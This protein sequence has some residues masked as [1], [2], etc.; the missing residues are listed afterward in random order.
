MPQPLVLL[1]LGGSAASSEFTLAQIAFTHPVILAAT[2][3]P[4]WARPHLARHLCVD[5]ADEAATTAAVK[6]LAA[7][8]DLGGI[9]TYTGEHLVTAARIAQQLQLP[10]PPTKAL[11]SCADR[12]ELRAKL[13]RHKVPVPVW[14]QAESP[15]AAVTVADGIGY[16]VVIRSRSGS[17]SSGQADRG[18][19]VAGMCARVRS[20]AAP[21]HPLPRGDVLVERRLDGPQVAAE[22]VVLESG[23]VQI[24]AITRTTLGP[25]PARQAV[26]HCVYAHDA[27]LHNRLLRQTVARAVEALG[28]TLGV[29]HIEMTLTSRGPRITD[30]SAHLADDLIPLLVK[31][32]TGVN[33]PRI[34]ADLAVGR[35]PNLAPTRQ[36]AAAVHFA[37]PEVSGRLQHVSV[38]TPG[39]GPLVDRTAVTRE[40]GHQVE[41][42][43]QATAQ[44]RLAHWVVLGAEAGDCHAL[45]DQVMY[46]LQADIAPTAAVRAA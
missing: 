8:H 27:L 35:L 37:Y 10:G 26:R 12:A 46:D 2:T 5:P 30:I 7:T 16:P 38:T 29:L 28:I 25:P 9:L 32:A 4:A 19:E 44:D 33:L 17:A 41:T 42:A 24:V 34:A 43:A 11:E 20:H 40:P 13:A 6:A 21:N 23:D 31:R 36:R 39:S 18:S 15:E 45:L 1:G 3:A 22:T 14:A